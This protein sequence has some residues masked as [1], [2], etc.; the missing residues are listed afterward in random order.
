MSGS[1]SDVQCVVGRVLA[2]ELGKG[3]RAE[4]DTPGVAVVA[5]GLLA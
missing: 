5:A 4:T 2:G 1:A 3:V